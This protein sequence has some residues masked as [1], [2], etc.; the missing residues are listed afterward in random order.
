ML[1]CRPGSFGLSGPLPVRRAAGASLRRTRRV[2]AM[3]LLH[4]GPVE[5]VVTVSGSTPAAAVETSSSAAAAA[6]AAET[7]A[8]AAA[9]ETSASAAVA[10]FS[11]AVLCGDTGVPPLAGLLSAGHFP[12]PGADRE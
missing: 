1:G 8:S 11:F 3:A 9:A 4:V 10:A 6:A 7:S 2:A 12:G 5:S